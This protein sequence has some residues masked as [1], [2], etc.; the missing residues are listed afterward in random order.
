MQGRLPIKRVYL[1]L[2]LLISCSLVLSIPALAAEATTVSSPSA[3]IKQKLKLLQAEIASKAAKLSQ[4]VQKKLENRAYIG[5]LKS[6]TGNELTVEVKNEIKVVRF[7]KFTESANLKSGI[8]SLV[9]GNFMASLGDIDENGVLIAKKIIKLQTPQASPSSYLWGQVVGKDK[10][11]L[12]IKGKNGKEITVA[13]DQK[14]AYLMGKNK[15]SFFDIRDKKPI[16]AVGSSLNGP[17]LKA[18]FI[19]IVPYSANLKPKVATQSSQA[20]PSSSKAK[21]P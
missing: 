14:T 7:N 20:S 6:K 12:V 4:T 11:Q 16:I 10:H 19:Y 3:D 18:R 17:V 1:A 15:A 13:T 9:R 5:S 2:S 21:K 8:S